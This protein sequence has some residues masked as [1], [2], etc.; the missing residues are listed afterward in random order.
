MLY[1]NEGVI[2]LK[3]LQLLHRLSSDPVTDG[4]RLVD[5]E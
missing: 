4:F 1:L 3:T 2:L 5:G